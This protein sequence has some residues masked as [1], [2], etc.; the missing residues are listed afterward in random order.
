MSHQEEL[1]PCGLC[2]LAP[3][4]I[5]VN[6]EVLCIPGPRVGVQG[7]ILT[8]RLQGG[9]GRTD[10]H[11]GATAETHRFEPSRFLVAGRGR[12]TSVLHSQV[13]ILTV[14]P[15]PPAPHGPHPVGQCCPI[16]QPLITCG[17]R[18]LEMRLILAEV[19]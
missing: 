17:S 1:L 14:R 18:T 11:V 6:W 16:R 8:P 15:S 2:L 12:Q 7:K 4:Q 9:L 3:T 13:L 10:T 19:D 5:C